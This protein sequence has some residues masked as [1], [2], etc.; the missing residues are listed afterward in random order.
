VYWTAQIVLSGAVVTHTI[1]DYRR[2]RLD[3]KPNAA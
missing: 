1:G 3:A 2:G